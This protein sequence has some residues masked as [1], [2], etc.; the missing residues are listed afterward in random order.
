MSQARICLTV[1]WAS[2]EASTG[3][4]LGFHWRPLEKVLVREQWRRILMRLAPMLQIGN[5]NA[6]SKVRIRLRSQGK[7][8][9]QTAEAGSSEG[10]PGRQTSTRP[11]KQ[12]TSSPALAEERLQAQMWLAPWVSNPFRNMLFRVWPWQRRAPHDRWYIHGCGAQ[13]L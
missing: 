13:Q 4:P 10:E 3:R 6:R 11:A 5:P 7:A 2:T 12:R 8:S 9:P 1:H